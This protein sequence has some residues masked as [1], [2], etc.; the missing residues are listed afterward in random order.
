LAANPLERAFAQDSP[1]VFAVHHP[2]IGLMGDFTCSFCRLA[3]LKNKRDLALSQLHASG[4]GSG[5]LCYG[6]LPELLRHR[7]K[8]ALRLQNRPS[9]EKV[10]NS[11]KGTS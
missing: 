2:I 11:G 9:E 3:R 6:L 5:S 8:L 4:G 1:A 10:D 7:D